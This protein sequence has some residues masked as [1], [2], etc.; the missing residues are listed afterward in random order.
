MRSRREHWAWMVAVE[1]REG[2]VGVDDRGFA[3]E[4][5]HGTLG[6]DARG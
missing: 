3:V 4:V 2:T 6:V 5:R 1:V